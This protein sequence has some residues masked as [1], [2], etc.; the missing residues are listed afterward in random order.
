MCVWLCVGV[1]RKQKLP[2][3][4][5]LKYKPASMC[6]HACVRSCARIYDLQY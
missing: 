4:N 1:C 5:K 2:Y 3:G 6:M